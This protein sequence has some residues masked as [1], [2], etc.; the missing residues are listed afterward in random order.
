MRL[1]GGISHDS[2]VLSGVPEGTVL[3]PFLFIILMW[4]I[5]SGISS[6]C[7]VSFADDTR[8]YYGMSNVF[9]KVI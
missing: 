1:Q 3:G 7:I 5:N 9:Y 6:S 8:L 4:D 2:P